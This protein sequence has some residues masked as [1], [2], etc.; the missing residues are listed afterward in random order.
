MDVLTK[1]SKF[2]AKEFD[3]FAK[4]FKIFPKKYSTFAKR[5]LRTSHEKRR[6]ASETAACDTLLNPHGDLGEPLA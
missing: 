2:F 6:E 4:N 5:L 3:F 1:K